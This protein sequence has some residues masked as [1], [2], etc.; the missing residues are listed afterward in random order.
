MGKTKEYFGRMR[1]QMQ[2]YYARLQK[3]LEEQEYYEWY[4]KKK[5]HREPEN[6]VKQN[7]N[8]K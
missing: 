6:N 2:D 1:E 4:L 5:A 3:T 7:N 8:H